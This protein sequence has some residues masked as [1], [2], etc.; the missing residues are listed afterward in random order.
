MASNTDKN[1]NTTIAELSKMYDSVD[2][3]T[4]IRVYDALKQANKE[5]KKIQAQYNKFKR[6]G[7]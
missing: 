4:R 6:Y 2:P 5:S 3:F 1:Y 7:K